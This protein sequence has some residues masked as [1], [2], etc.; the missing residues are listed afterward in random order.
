ML[1]CSHWTRSDNGGGIPPAYKGMNLTQTWG[2]NLH[3]GI[4]VDGALL[5]RQVPASNCE[6]G[7]HTD[8]SVNHTVSEWV[9]WGSQR[10]ELV[11][12][13]AISN[14]S[15]QSNVDIMFLGHSCWVLLR[16]RHETEAGCWKIAVGRLS[17]ATYPQKADGKG[18]ASACVSSS[19]LKKDV[20]GHT[21]SW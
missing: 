10:H 18:Q 2:P 17:S 3:I 9:P 11:T 1:F 12:T 14:L 13:L 5:L 19:T 7:T 15:L 8:H 16:K 4:G 20:A 21:T 6:S